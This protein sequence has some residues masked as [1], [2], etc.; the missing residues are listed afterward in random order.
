MLAFWAKV[1]GRSEE[2]NWGGLEARVEKGEADAEEGEG[3]KGL[4]GVELVE[5]EKGFWLELLAAKVELNR[6][7]PRFWG[8]W[9]S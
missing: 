9:F 6:L 2:G 8:T 7:L 5:V 3:A 1:A 4:A